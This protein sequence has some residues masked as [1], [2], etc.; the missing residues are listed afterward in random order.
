[1]Q[2]ATSWVREESNHQG[3]VR[4]G[5]CISGLYLS[6]YPVTGTVL[7]SRVR[8]GGKVQHTVVLSKELHLPFG[9]NVRPVG[10]TVGINEEDITEVFI[11]DCV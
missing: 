4:E 8:Y 1:M 7:E 9:S 10:S 11:E 6:T 3:W 5:Q 2:T